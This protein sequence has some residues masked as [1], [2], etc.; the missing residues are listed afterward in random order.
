MSDQTDTLTFPDKMNLRLA[1]V[2]IDMSEQRLRTLARE[3]AI[4]GAAK[5]EGGNWVFTKEGLAEYNELRASGSTR[6][7][8]VRGDGKAFVIRVK[9]QD[10]TDVKEFLAT[11]EI[12]LE[13]RYNYAKQREYQ[14]RRKAEK[15]AQATAQP[16]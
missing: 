4:P 11:K 8:A 9:P 7:V 14:A 15:A 1:S 2:F 5:D 10:L 6:K 13:P 16:E 3:N 12:E